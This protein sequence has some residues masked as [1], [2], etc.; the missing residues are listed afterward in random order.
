MMDSMLDQETTLILLTVKKSKNCETSPHVDHDS[1]ERLTHISL[2]CCSRGV[3]NVPFVSASYLAHHSALRQVKN[4]YS[5]TTLESDMAFCASIRS[6]VNEPHQHF[7]ALR[8][9]NFFKKKQ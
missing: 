8:F 5:S 1:R 6:K 3:W 9:D 4:P 2:L 7:D